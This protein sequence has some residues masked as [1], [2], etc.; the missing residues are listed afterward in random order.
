MQSALIRKCSTH[1]ILLGSFAV[2]GLSLGTGSAFAQEGEV[3]EIIV[4]GSRIARDPNLGSSV[5]VQSVTADDIQL[6]GRMDVV[7]VIRQIPALM[8]SETGDGSSSPVGSAFDSDTSSVLDLSG[9]AVLQLRG[10]G[11]SRTLVLVD[12]RRHVAGS[13][14]NA[15]VDINTIPLPLIER[16]EV[17]TGGASAIYGADAVTGVVNFIMKD[18]FVGLE[19]TAQGGMS[20][21][22]DGEDFRLGGV[23]GTNFA[24]DRG[25]FAI[26]VDYRKRE[27]M[28]M[29]D[30]SWS[31]NNAI[32]ANEGGHPDLRFQA[33]EIT[34]AETNFSSFYALSNGQYPYGLLIPSADDF[35][36]NFNASFPGT[37]ITTADLTSGE[38]ALIDRAD[39]SPT[40]L[41]DRFLTFSISSEGGVVLPGTAFAE[42]IDLDGNGVD[43]CF[44]SFQGFNGVLD[45]SPPGFGFLG[46]CWH[47][48][49]GGA[50]RVYDDGVIIGDFNSFGGDGVHGNGYS[51][52]SLTPDDERVNITLMGNYA[53]AD[54]LT[55]FA[56]FK[57]LDQETKLFDTADG[58]YDLLRVL[59]DN[60]FIPAALAPF[61]V[62]TDGFYVT[63]DPN[64]FGDAGRKIDREL[65]RFVI[66]MEGEF[67]NGWGFEISLNRGQTKI[68]DN[69]KGTTIMDRYF[70]AL[71]VVTDPGSGE[72]I[73]RSELDG[74]L[75]PTT[76]FGIPTFD[77]GFFTFNPMD[78]SCQPYNIF[79]GPES[80]SEAAK[81]WLLT[82]TVHESKIEQTV[83]SV[84]VNGDTGFG[85]D[86]G[87]IAFAAGAEFRIEKST[88][89]FDSLTLGIC[90]ITTPDCEAGTRISDLSAF[91]QETLVWDPRFLSNNA[92]GNYDV[93]DVFGEVD[94]PLLSGATFAEELSFNAAA[95]FS[96]YSNVGDTVTWQVG[97]VWA[98]VE[99]IRFRSTVSRA[100][101]A[102]NIAE[103]FNPILAATF[104][105]LDPCVQTEI[106]ALTANDPAAGAIR[107]ANC[108]ADGIPVGFVD[109]LSARVS[110]A[111][112]GNPDLTEEEA[113]T[114][115]VG[116]VFTPT[117]FEGFTLSIDYWDIEITNAID[118]VAAQDIVDNCYDSATFPNTFCTQFR[119]VADPTSAQFL[120]FDFIQQSQL[121]F[122]KLE[123]SG[124]DF[125]ATYAFELGASS[126]TVG[127]QGTKVNEIDEFFDPSDP[128]IVDPELGELRRPELSYTAY[129]NWGLGPF[130]VQWTSLYQDKQALNRVE[131]ETAVFQFG[132]A[133]FSDDFWAHNL[134][135]SWDFSESVRIFGGINNVTDEEPFITETAYP[136]GPQG[137]YF[138][139]GLNWTMQ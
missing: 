51:P 79:N 7:E 114:F 126:F 21:K 3:E 27:S 48:D 25:N 66:G 71:D 134:T 121:N 57:Y 5:A 1:A 62:Q 105:P 8:T 60:P 16:V 93:W 32:A 73:C 20:S 97:L 11:L 46:G 85:F 33:G 10:M 76:R 92:G 90:P 112:S 31:A 40:Q 44:D 131:I 108:R 26:A 137:T 22:G 14:G 130:F 84:I 37:P 136:V 69:N 113:D 109:P 74:S 100:V 53:V 99:D 107:L 4:T 67:D 115:T 29:G 86:A 129:L 15:A 17:L 94:V 89:I 52:Y 42:G 111:T 138:F 63:R 6:S 80:G 117:F 128:T 56:E 54:N 9:E 36:T 98:P 59:P 64:D 28:T 102:P 82:T 101:R 139:L 87:E 12:G 35:V 68:T 133:G 88:T 132:P 119:R 23:W 95:R 122:G 120:G 75:Y 124:V 123:S 30:R 104:R 38:L 41:I 110:G 70:A 55:L 127:A 43:D 103:L 65:S 58:F 50:V 13:P 19:I 81:D 116:F 72:P 77:A 39:N 45:F 125:A 91:G 2:I 34:A 18:N 96:Q 118:F 61:A 135:A 106:D 78:G 24:D 47:V 83:L 49:Q